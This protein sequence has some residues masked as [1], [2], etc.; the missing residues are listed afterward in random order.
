[1]LHGAAHS[2]TCERVP[3]GTTWTRPHGHSEAH[4]V[5]WPQGLGWGSL[6]VVPSASQL[7]GVHTGT[8][9]PLPPAVLGPWCPSV[10]VRVR[11]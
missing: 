3:R 11:L 8:S 10:W 2:L 5:W 9:G 6:L 1:M 7:T 4:A